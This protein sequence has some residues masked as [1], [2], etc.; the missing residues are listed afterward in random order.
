[1]DAV[2]HAELLHS[3]IKHDLTIL[4]RRTSIEIRVPLFRFEMWEPVIEDIQ[5]GFE[6]LGPEKG[7]WGADLWWCG[8][9][10]QELA[11]STRA[12]SISF[13]A[14]IFT[15]LYCIISTPKA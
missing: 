3:H 6:E 4:A 13:P 1:M 14:L 11:Q 12:S 15:T 10:V 2:H 8:L 5:I 9:T 7:D